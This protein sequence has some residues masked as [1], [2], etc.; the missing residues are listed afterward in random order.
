MI[1]KAVFP[2]KYKK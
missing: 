2:S 1:K